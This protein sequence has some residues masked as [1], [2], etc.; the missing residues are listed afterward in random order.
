[1]ARVQPI[2]TV[3]DR[4]WLLPATLHAMDQT[5]TPCR[6]MQVPVRVRRA[7]LPNRCDVSPP[8]GLLSG[9]CV[10]G[11]QYLL[12]LFGDLFAGLAGQPAK[13]HES[14]GRRLDVQ[15]LW[16]AISD[17]FGSQRCIPM[18]WFVGDELRMILNLRPFSSH[19]IL[20]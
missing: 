11:V 15:W 12:D 19:G 3:P 16:T 7:R 20:E 8:F 2:E 17:L 5:W 10:D 18:Q 13:L 1:M 14:N 6:A 4:H 9:R